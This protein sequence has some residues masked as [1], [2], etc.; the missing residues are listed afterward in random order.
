MTPGHSVV[1]VNGVEPPTSAAAT[2]L[3]RPG[4]YDPL[5]DEPA[6]T[7]PSA[8]SLR[9][10]RKDGQTEEPEPPPVP[11]TM[12]EFLSPSALRDTAVPEGSQLVGDYHIERGSPFVLGGAP[13]V[14]KSRAAVALAVAGATGA[15]WFGLK[16]HRRFR[17][18]ILQAENG[19]VRLK[20]EFSDLDCAALDGWVCVTPPPP[21]GFAFV[22]R[23]FL[24]QLRAAVTAFKPDVFLL[25]PWNQVVRDST[26]RDY[27]E[28][29][30]RVRACLPTGDDCPALGIVA[31]TR[32]PRMGEK[33]SGR[34]LLNLLSGSYVLASVPRSVFIIQPATDDTD[35]GRIVFTVAKNNNG[36]LGKRSVWERRNGLFAPVENFDWETFDGGGGSKPRKGVTEQHIR[37]VFDDGDS[38]ML[39]KAAAEKLQEVAGVGRT[40][41]YEALKVEGGEFSRLLC[42]REDKTIGLLVTGEL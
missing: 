3:Q 18:M 40:V 7:C 35:D 23:H 37:E 32:K 16:V 28:G 33:A 34:S 10:E 8:G 20:N 24:A 17:T 30:E 31:H 39:L 29:F 13:G 5:A 36:Q 12:V 19:R 15:D 14:G 38:F 21:Y 27:S 4:F 2:V 6:V 22:D 9:G 25:D 11:R 26:E 1:G 41:A 42:R